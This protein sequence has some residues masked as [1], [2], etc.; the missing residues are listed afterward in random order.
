MKKGHFKRWVRSIFYIA[1]LGVLFVGMIVV[2]VYLKPGS[3]INFL[4]VNKPVEPD[5]MVVEGWISDQALQGALE[6][7]R[8]QGYSHI[9][10]TG[11]PLDSFIMLAVN[12]YIEFNP[13]PILSEPGDSITLRLSGSPAK[14]IYPHYIL[15]INGIEVSSGTAGEG[16]EDYTIVPSPRDSMITSIQIVFNND[17]HALGEDRN[18]YVESVM[19]GKQ[20]ILARSNGTKVY[21]GRLENPFFLYRTDVYSY[22]EQ[23]REKLLAAGIYSDSISSVPAPSIE[24]NR[25]YISALAIARWVDEEGYSTHFFNIYSEGV[26]ARRTW[27]L[28]KYALRKRAGAVG[29]LSNSNIEH[30]AMDPK[31][32]RGTIIRELEGNLYYRTFFN[33]AKMK[34]DFLAGKP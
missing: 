30:L 22:A 18:L 12:G 10:T 1:G 17:E 6:S 9:V 24:I 33:K 13:E 15:Y 29:I 2:F 4:Y 8:K 11:G 32:L 5:I 16:W 23:C 34:R 7:F 19:L 26:H 20:L 3:V 21:A 28:Y 14:G 27:F 31:L 25:T